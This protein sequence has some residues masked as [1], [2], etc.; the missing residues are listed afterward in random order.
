MSQATA[1]RSSSSPR[2][3]KSPYLP[4]GSDRIWN[5]SAGPGALPE[6]VLRQVQQDIWNIG[7]SGVGI[8]EHSHRGKLIDRVFEEVHQLVRDVLGV[9]AGY[10]V[11]FCTGGASTQGH[12]IP[13]NF[14]PKDR[15]ADYFDTGVWANKAIKQAAYVGNPHTCASSKDKNHSYIPSPAQTKY[16]ERPAYVHFTS[17]NTIYGTQFAKDAEPTPPPGVPLICDMSS[18]IA[19]RPVNVSKYAMIYAGAQKNLGPAGS[20]LVIIKDEL[21]AQD[22]KKLPDLLRYSET[23]KELSRWNTPPVFPIYVVGLVLK[24]YQKLGGLAAIERTN[25]AKAKLIYDVLDAGFY[26]PH[27]RKDSRS[28]MNITFRL[29]NETLEKKFMTEAEA[30]GFSSI[31]GHRSVGGVRASVYNSFP[32]E[33]CEQFAQFLRDFAKANG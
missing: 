17:N 7:G 22:N 18:D 27:A 16:S 24:H 23:A 20:T 5:L 9:P 4:A 15:T 3:N 28:L 33:G 21:M 1:S 19:S 13:M 25:L 14:L 2:P 10:T 6:E 11:M 32:T 29:P 30:A 31:A 12:M 8:L 26:D